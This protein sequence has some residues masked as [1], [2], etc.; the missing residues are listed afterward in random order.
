MSEKRKPAPEG[1]SLLQEVLNHLENVKR[2]QGYYMARCPETSY[3]KHGDIKPSLMI[4]ES[5]WFRC[6]NSA[7]PLH[8]GGSIRLL[9]ERIG[10]EIKDEEDHD[11]L[12]AK[13]I[14]YIA[15]R[16]KLNNE[17]A[18]KFMKRFNIKPVNMFGMDGIL[19]DLFNGQKKFRAIDAKEF[20]LI[21]SKEAP[22]PFSGMIIPN[23]ETSSIVVVTEGTFDAL[24]CWRLGIPAISKE[25]GHYSE[26]KLIDWLANNYMVPHLAFDN[27]EAGEEYRVRFIKKLADRRIPAYIWLIPEEFKDL[28][29]AFVAGKLEEPKIIHAIEWIARKHEHLMRAF[30]ETGEERFRV[31]FMRKILFYYNLIPDKASFDAVKKVMYDHGIPPEDWEEELLKIEITRQNEAKREQILAVLDQHRQRISQGFPL[32]EEIETLKSSLATVQTVEVRTV[33]QRPD[34]IEFELPPS[35]TT[36]LLPNLFFYPSDI[37]LISARTKHGK[38]TFALNLMKE[39]LD[40]GYKVLFVTYELL[41]RQIFNFFTGICQGKNFTQVSEI[42]RRNIAKR[43]AG[44]LALEDGLEIEEISAYVRTFQPHVFI[45]D[46]DQMIRTS[47]RFESEERRVSFIV[48]TLKNL[49]LDTKSLCILL[50]QENEEGQARWSREKEFYASVHLRLE[51]QDDSITCEVKLNRYGKAGGKFDIRIDWQTRKATRPEAL[52]NWGVE[53]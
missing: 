32:N 28:N 2:Y 23:P 40:Q 45:I 41:A 11:N 53:L 29:E 15:K 20:R 18:E 50:S 24:T 19:I 37:L 16:L 36:P 46:Y 9:A 39:F 38:T 31:E 47:G 51:K 49:A 5:G 30:E 12:R 7:C 35:F 4:G 22:P 34:L 44:L 43:Y 25:G 3:H 8:E 13:A 26:D 1:A 27:D 10:I 17:Q 33:D 21:G 48:Q 6:L 52:D 14:E 42:D